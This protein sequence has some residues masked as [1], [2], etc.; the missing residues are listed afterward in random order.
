MLENIVFIELK[1]RG[2]NIF[3]HSNKKECDFIIKEKL[4]I[5]EA[6]QETTSIS[7]ITVKNREIDGLIEALNI[8]NLSQGYILTEDDEDELTISNKRIIIYPVWKWLLSV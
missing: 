4:T 3:Y 5:M 2:K 7:D 6:Y 1:R 8:Y